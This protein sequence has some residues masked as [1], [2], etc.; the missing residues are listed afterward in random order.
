[1]SNQ[2]IDNIIEVDE[3]QKTALD[4]LYAAGDCTSKI[5]QIAVSVGQ[6]AVAGLK[7]SEYIRNLRG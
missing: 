7:I 4:G 6:G 3:N 2:T 1:M 5:R